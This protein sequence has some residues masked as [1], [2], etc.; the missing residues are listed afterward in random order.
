M[1]M[2]VMTWHTC[3]VPHLVCVCVRVCVCVCA[4]LC[5]CLCV[6]FCVCVC[7]RLCVCACVCV[8][9]YVVCAGRKW[10]NICGSV[11]TAGLRCAGTHEWVTN[12]SLSHGTHIHELCNV[13][14]CFMWMNHSTHV[15]FYCGTAMRWYAGMS[16][17]HITKSQHTYTWVVQRSW[18][19]S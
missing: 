16:R 17:E 6:C 4:C 7:V 19:F 15:H 1:G 11:S 12:I 13:R 9:V 18:I 2:S 3:L 10:C 14:G 8:C 5:V